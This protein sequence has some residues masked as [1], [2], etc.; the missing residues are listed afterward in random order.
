M[1]KSLQRLHTLYVSYAISAM[2]LAIW[3]FAK[4]QNLKDELSLS[5]LD[6]VKVDAEAME[7]EVLAPA[8]C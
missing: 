7:V 5:H 3:G 1:N 4:V 8:A 2:I 6:F